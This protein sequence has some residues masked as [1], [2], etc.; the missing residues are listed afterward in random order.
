MTD[1][2]VFTPEMA[3]DLGYERGAR[4][5]IDKAMAVL[6]VLSE[7]LEKTGFSEPFKSGLL[8]GID[9]CIEFLGDMSVPQIAD[10]DDDRYSLTESGE[11][12]SRCRK[13]QGS[14]LT[15][16]EAWCGECHGH[17]MMLQPDGKLLECSQATPCQGCAKP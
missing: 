11:L 16:C 10:I 15:M 5:A 1:D 12:A 17:T 2:A 13:C 7:R 3:F 6:A 9:E 8:S 4:D 14:G